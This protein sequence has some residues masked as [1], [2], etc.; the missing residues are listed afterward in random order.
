MRFLPVRI[1]V[2]SSAP[3]FK[4]MRSA[5]HPDVSGDVQYALKPNWMFAS[6]RSVVTHGSPYSYDTHVP[7]LVYAPRWY[8]PGSVDTPVDIASIAPTLAQLL[9]VARPPAA[10]AQVLPVQAP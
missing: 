8:K 2:S 6:T 4:A 7:L 3:L 10:A 9:G 1:S 5:W